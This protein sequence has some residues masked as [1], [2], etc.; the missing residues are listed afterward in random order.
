MLPTEA[1][2]TRLAS[3]MTQRTGARV[4]VASCAPLGSYLSEDKPDQ[5]LPPR[6]TGPDCAWSD[7]AGQVQE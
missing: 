4:T 3:G 7:R 1:Y 5:A 2:L 6:I